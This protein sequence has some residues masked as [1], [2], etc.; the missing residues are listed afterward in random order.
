MKASMEKGFELL[1]KTIR[2]AN[3]SIGFEDRLQG[4]LDLLVRK[5]EIERAALFFVTPEQETLELKK[6]SPQGVPWNSRSFHMAQT[7][8]KEV[9]QNR[10]AVL[11]PQLTRKEHKALLKN[12]FFKGFNSLI[13]L[14]VGDDNVLYG[15]L[16]LLS[17]QALTPDPPHLEALDLVAWELAGIIRNSR[18]YT[19][20]KK[21]I[22]EL[23]VL[24]Q[25]GKVIGSTLELNDLI[26]KTVA[27]TA[28]VIN[29]TGSTLM[30]LEK[31]SETVLVESEFGLVPSLVKGKIHQDILDQKGDHIYNRGA[32]AYSRSQLDLPF[33]DEKAKG[34]VEPHLISSYMCIALNFKG[35]YRG[36]L[37]VYEKIGLGG[38]SDAFFNEED[39]SVL[40]TIGNIIASSLENALTFQR[41][42]TLARKNEW[43][44]RNLSTLYQI[45]SAMMT[46]ASL[47]DHPQIILEAITLEEGLG[48][49]RAVLLLADEDR[50]I[51]TPKAWSIQR[52]IKKG[53][54][55]QPGNGLTG[56]GLSRFL[57]D[58]AAQIRNLRPDSDHVFKNIKIPL[59]KESGILARTF[60]EGRTFVVEQAMEDPDT[61]KD[62]A[63]R[64]KLDAF[65]SIPMY[66]KD[67]VVGVIEVDN[68]I[69]KRP[70][71]QEDLYLL[72]LLAHQ[73]GLAFENARLYDFIEKTNDELKVARER[74]I[75]SEKMV[76]IGEMTSGLAHE[77][78][79]PLVS[80]GGFVRRLNKKFQGDDQAQSYFQVIINEVER[81]EKILNEMTDFSQN[82]RGNYKEWD[83]NQI[84]EE[85]L[86]LIQRELDEGHIGVQKKW[87][88]IPKVFGDNR[89]LRHVFYNLF[90]NS[91][92]A[93][94]H[95][96]LLTLRTFLD[97]EPGR[98]WIACE[99]KD[100]GGGI[101]PELLHNIFNPFF[102]TKDHGSGLGLSIVHKIITRHQGEV[103]IDNRPGE[104]VSFLIKFP[105]AKEAQ[106]YFGK[107]KIFEEENH[108]KD[109]NRR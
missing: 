103:D 100:N 87:G 24:Y 34:S 69:D 88:K 12:P 70:I 21:R 54:S 92:Q 86:N 105:L 53:P 104:G 40:S 42:E 108:E 64:L 46:T 73:A 38:E 35:L 97:K 67:K 19:E 16:G 80:I 82:H 90:L 20:S 91:C 37:C 68:F 17:R 11:I 51:L 47:K 81:L 29:A 94:P 27:I 89:Q 71:T 93:L 63:K 41:I 33:K 13:A 95:G 83:L 107:I 56:S 25:V 36:R 101:P 26:E 6:V 65:A 23:S 32:T 22:A 39:L 1:K 52:E 60:L 43:M 44:V 57:V 5:E 15:V 109:L 14:P 48:F 10:S 30:I 28:Q 74:L 31:H 79:N 98:S 96:G 76:A 4:V 50:K 75:E 18:V 72:T 77:I 99:V 78:R 49:N 58:Q 66:A 2:V 9:I 85:A 106:H 59:T 61:N 84:V 7:P 62:L 55:G 45:D 3:S 8:I 102:T